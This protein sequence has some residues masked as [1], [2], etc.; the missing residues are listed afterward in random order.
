[1]ENQENLDMNVEDNE[2]EQS[3]KR[4]KMPSNADLMWKSVDLSETDDDKQLNNIYFN[5]IHISSSFM[6]IL[7]IILQNSS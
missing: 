1:M 4:A 6:I 5:L 3:A 7:R 2:K